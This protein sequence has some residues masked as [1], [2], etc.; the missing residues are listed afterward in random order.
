VQF[1][2]LMALTVELLAALCALVACRG[3]PG[4]QPS[5]TISV[6]G[7]GNQI[8]STSPGSETLFAVRSETGLGSADVEQVSGE[9][10]QE[11]VFRLYLRGLEEF[12]FEYD[13][14]RVVVS[15]SSHGDNAVSERVL[16][17]GSGEK[18]I[19][20]DSPYWMP[21]RIVTA[22]DSSSPKSTGYFEVRAP[23]EYIRGKY[24]AFSIRWTDFYR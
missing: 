20:P 24:R 16:R 9:P 13:D 19:G 17:D 22:S 15:V 1:R 23:K 18:T 8:T 4:E 14:L 21:V 2:S 12:D 7:T 3:G 5:Y 11:V 10:P 6:S